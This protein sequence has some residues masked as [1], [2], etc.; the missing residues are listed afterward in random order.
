MLKAEVKQFD[1]LFCSKYPAQQ[2]HRSFQNNL[3]M[4]FSFIFSIVYMAIGDGAGKCIMMTGHLL[5]S[6]NQYNFFRSLPPTCM[7]G[8]IIIAAQCPKLKWDRRMFWFVVKNTGVLLL[9]TKMPV[10]C[11]TCTVAHISVK[12]FM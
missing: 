11:M 2:F 6:S 8:G 5:F 4:V 10:L 7:P 1:V 12:T 3:K 9:L